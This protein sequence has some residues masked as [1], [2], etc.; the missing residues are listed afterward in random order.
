[1]AYS[2]SPLHYY[3]Y[4]KALSPFDEIHYAGGNEPHID[5][6]YN[7]KRWFIRAILEDYDTD[8][9]GFDDYQEYLMGTSYDSAASKLDVASNI[10]AVSPTEGLRLTWNWLPNVSYKIYFTDNLAHDWTLI[11]NAYWYFLVWPEI[12]ESPLPI[13]TPSGFYKIVAD[14]VDPVTD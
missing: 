2:S 4:I 10:D 9:D 5:I 1:M 12:V 11:D 7:N 6:N 8:G 14:V 3:D 13:T